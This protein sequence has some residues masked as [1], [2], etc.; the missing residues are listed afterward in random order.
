MLS[1]LNVFE[2]HWYLI[3]MLDYSFISYPDPDGSGF[4][5]PFRIRIL[6]TRIRILKTRIRIL[7]TRIRI[8]PL[9]NQWD[10]I[11]VLDLNNLNLDPDPGFWPNLDPD[12]GYTINFER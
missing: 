11:S 5:S 6:K 1:C 9:T 10:L 3:L 2:Q 8:R 4:F 12:P 7:K